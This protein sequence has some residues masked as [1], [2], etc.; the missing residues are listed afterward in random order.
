MRSATNNDR[1]NGQ[2]HSAGP[3]YEAKNKGNSQK[4]VAS[5]RR[6]FVYFQSHRQAVIQLF[7]CMLVGSGLS[8]IFPFLTQALVDFGIN[9]QNI[10]FIYTLLLGR[11]ML[12]FGETFIELLRTRIL[13]HIGIRM[14]ISVV[15]DFL[16]KMMRLPIS[17]FDSRSVGDILQRMDGA[18]RIEFFFTGTA[19]SLL[20]SLLNLLGFGIIVFVYSPTIFTIF[21]FGSIVYSGWLVAFMK[22]RAEVDTEQFEQMSYTRN[23][24]LQML[25]GMHEIKA[26]GCEQ[27]KLQEWAHT[28]SEILGT[29]IRALTIDQWQQSGAMSINELKNIAITFLAAKQVVDGELTLG[30]ML[31]VQYI[32]GQLNAPVNQLLNFMRMTQDAKLSFS[33]L[34]EVHAVEDEQAGNINEACIHSKANITIENLDFTYDGSKKV[35]QNLHITIL[36]GR[37]NAIV[38]VSGSGKTTL[39][40]LLLKFYAPTK[41]EIKLGNMDLHQLDTQAWRKNCGL[42]AQDGYIFTDTVSRNIAFGE[43][44]IDYKRLYNAIHMANLDEMIER[45]PQGLDTVIGAQAH[46]LSQGQK[47]RVLIARAIYK[48]P[49]YIF[50]DEATNALDARNERVIIENMQEFLKGKTAVIIAHRLSTVK[51]ADQII[52]LDKGRVVEVG[53]HSDLIELRGS[54][55]GLVRNQLELGI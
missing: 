13:V 46:G 14:T 32:I 26:N 48:N 50:F 21:L 35:L 22:R 19:I 16:A 18:R 23:H 43:Y 39:I 37:V 44:E 25:E 11:L 27:Y 20:Y 30:M 34:M 15:A 45:L 53:T 47:Q 41:G 4:E 31:A 5:L 33:R 2:F 42:V 1:E 17:Y 9:N 7:F 36:S 12:F 54:Y 49:R 29:R 51:N 8:L 24:V 40:K 55:H 52:V 38:G 3:V 10:G 28:Q 6:L